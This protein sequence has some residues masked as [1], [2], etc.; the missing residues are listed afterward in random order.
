MTK[1]MAALVGGLESE[2]VIMNS[3]TCNLHLMMIAF[4]RPTSTRYKIL[5]E[6]K[7]FPSDYHVICSQIQLNGFN[8]NEALLELEPDDGEVNIRNE[9]IKK[10]ID[11]QG[12]NIALIM[13]GGIQYYSGQLFDMESITK[14]G[15]EKGC[16]VGFDLA[17]AVGNVPISLH[18]W[19]CDFA[20]WCTYKYMN[21]GPGS[22]AGCFVHEKHTLS[23]SSEPSGKYEAVV[24]R[25]LAGW[26]GHRAKD[27]FNMEPTFIPEDGVNGFR[28]S[29]PPV[30][31]VACVRASL[32]VF[33]KAG[34]GMERLRRKSILLTGYLEHLLLTEL[35][36]LVKILTPS[37][38]LQR[39]C[40]L[41]VTFEVDSTA[42]ASAKS[43][44]DI[45]LEGLKN[46]DVICDIRRP[47]VIRIA[48]TPLYNSFTDVRRFVTILKS[49]LQ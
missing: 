1:S 21:C 28:L 40:Q 46:H 38:P 6:K 43:K 24:P 25:R 8:P 23:S 3:L 39:G 5:I 33:D 10:V 49:I 45:V 13:L 27:R 44:A 22:I 37:D 18:D 32:S 41:S 20:C 19:G 14:W 2:V 17:H 15:H 48:P 30:L 16:M 12:E 11:E 36:G 47:N 35:N 31:L 42:E 4:Y 7:A 34:P 26:W 29:N 9:K